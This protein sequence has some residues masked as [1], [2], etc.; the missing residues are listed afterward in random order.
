MIFNYNDME[1]KINIIRK[2]NKNLYIR[3]I[4]NEI[5]VTCNYLTTTKQI[6]KIINDNKNTII[7]MINKSN[8]KDELNNKFIIF[9]KE[10]KIIYNCEFN[11]EDDIIYIENEKKLIKWLNNYI[12]NTFNNHLMLWYNKFEENIPKPNLKIRKMKT[13]WG[14]CNLKN[15]NVTLNSE[16]IKYDIECLDYVI[17]H[18]LSHFIHSDHSKEFWK[19]VSKYKKDYKDL[20]KK[21]K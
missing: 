8:K 3:V 15:N 14:V 9:G 6:T 1:Y 16:L 18:E 20:R 7:K 12:L 17:V 10:Y 5:I 19:L 13:R 11:I 4:N 21:L 2:N